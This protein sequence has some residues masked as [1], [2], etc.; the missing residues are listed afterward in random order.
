[1]PRYRQPNVV[2]VQDSDEGAIND[3]LPHIRL[4][5]L[6]LIVGLNRYDVLVESF[7]GPNEDLFNFIGLAAPDDDSRAHRERVRGELK[8]SLVVSEAEIGALPDGNPLVVNGR[9]L[10]SELGLDFKD[11]HIL[12]FVVLA[13]QHNVLGTVLHSLGSLSGEKL[14]KVLSVALGLPATLVRTSLEE[15]APLISSGLL[16]VDERSQYPFRDKLESLTGLCDRMLLPQESLHSL[17]SGAFTVAGEPEELTL[18]DF[19]YLGARVE[20][21]AALLRQSIEAGI[22]GQNILIHGPAGVGKT[23]LAILLSKAA[24]GNCFQVAVKHGNHRLAGDK[25]LNAYVLAQGILK[26]HPRAIVMLD[27]AEDVND[28]V[29]YSDDGDDIFLS[30]PKSNGGRKGFMNALLETNQLPAIW[31]TNRIRNLD[32][33]FLRRFS[34]IMEMTIPPHRKRAEILAKHI[35]ELGV[36]PGWVEQAATNEALSPGLV[37]RAVK[38]VTTMISGGIQ[39]DPT[40]M[41]QEVLNGSLQ[42]QR[43]APIPA[44]NSNR[45]MS[46]RM[47]VINSDVHLESLVG[48]LRHHPQA[49]ILLSGPPGSGKSEFARQV[50]STL[51]LPVMVKRASDLLSAYVGETESAIADMFRRATAENACLV[52][53]EIDSLLNARESGSKRYEVSMVNELLVGLEGFTTGLCMFTTNFTTTLDQAFFRRFDIKVAFNY[54]TT[55]QVTTLLKESLTTLGLDAEIDRVEGAGRTLR[56]LTPG[57]FAAVIRQSRFRPVVSLEDLVDRLRHE[58]DHKAINKPTVIGFVRAA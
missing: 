43:S 13:H 27:E 55:T 16:S 22:Q 4:W 32:P 3:F 53:D 51:G 29:G 45:G 28:V 38:T 48:G 50:A 11:L 54:S 36:A 39:D 31:V 14:V 2:S 37:S 18:A 21:L 44:F 57:D 30:R 26:R 1:M 15:D 42:A 7:I 23:S 52:I 8:R 12:M 20:R 56:N 58:C 6:R 33:A 46:F 25:R 49:R 17:F 34:F 47:D 19:G 9:W 5:I 35:G 41:L 40:L 10:Q 24:G